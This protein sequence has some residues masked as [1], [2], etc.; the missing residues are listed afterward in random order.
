[1]FG[2]ETT[3]RE[4]A[5]LGLLTAAFVLVGSVFA[6]LTPL[7]A[8][9]DESVHIDMARH[10]AAHPTEIAGP[11]LRQTEG[12]RGAVVAA[13]ILDAPAESPVAAIPAERPDYGTF[14]DYG[15]DAEATDCP[16]RTCQNYHFIHPPAWYLLAAPFA[17]VL[18]G[19][20]FPATVVAL[21]TM[22][23]VIASSVVAA[24]WYL[25]R[26]LWPGRPRAALVAASIMALCGP[27]A[28]AAASA[29]NDGLLLPLMAVALALMA[30]ILRKGATIRRCVALGLV[31]SV[32]LLT[33]GQFLVIAPIG[34][35]AVLLA[36][37]PDGA[38]P[39]RH[40]A[41]AYLTAGAPGGLWWLRIIIDTGSTTPAGSEFVADFRPGPWNQKGLF[42]YFFMRIGDIVDAVPGQYG[43]WP[44]KFAE[45]PS[46]LLGAFHI[47]VVLLVLGWWVFRSWSKPTIDTARVV[48]LGSVPFLLLLAAVASSWE[49]YRET[50]YEYGLAGRYVY[51]GVP[52]L[53]V[54]ATAT[55]L[56]L[57]DRFRLRRT[58]RLHVL[59]LVV[60]AGAGSVTAVVVSMHS[61]YFTTDNSLL[62][63]R[64][65]IVAPVR[66]GG[67]VVAAF[68]VALVAV[69]GMAAWLLLDRIGPEP[70][71]PEWQPTPLPSDTSAAIPSPKPPRHLKRG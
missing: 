38:P 47:L 46:P 14:D 41:L 65:K 71:L 13:G 3:G 60:A 12:V 64:A 57:K 52:V 29:N 28:A 43:Y 50:G 10:Y 51:G 32:G 39:W 26:Q 54:M 49:T 17:A 8:N 16:Q 19:S 2:E 27:V 69:L 66:D 6:L 55:L 5:V 36:P 18:D 59:L 15:G 30:G 33:K 48:L 20:P 45:L 37:R 4:R 68:A 24:T 53:A 70:E 1:M 35:A 63:D 22:N 31:V 44:W 58:D 34:L 61:K 67:S 21:R 9:P 62:L 40:S 23:V 56:A 7:F 42:E 11:S 25:A